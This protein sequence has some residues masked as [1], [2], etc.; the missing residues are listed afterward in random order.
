MYF[1]TV[2]ESRFWWGSDSVP[3]TI[4]TKTRSAATIIT[5][6]LLQLN[7]HLTETASNVDIVIAFPYAA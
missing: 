5:Y 3:E 2:H 6:L 7:L 4:P 1:C